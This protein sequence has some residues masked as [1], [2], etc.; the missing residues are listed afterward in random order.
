[1]CIPV[2][3]VD[4]VFGDAVHHECIPVITIDDVL[5]DAVHHEH[6]EEATRHGHHA[7]E[8]DHLPLGNHD[9]TAAHAL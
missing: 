7:Q 2:I 6:G 9:V 4:D 5:G 3:T 8:E 1:M